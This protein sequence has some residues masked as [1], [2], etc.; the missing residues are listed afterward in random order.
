MAEVMLSNPQ[1]DELYAIRRILVGMY[2]SH[3][4]TLR[5]DPWRLHY[6]SSKVDA[7][8]AAIAAFI[9]RN[10]VPAAHQEQLPLLRQ[11]VAREVASALGQTG[12][13]IPGGES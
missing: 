11:D 7:M 5:P 8:D 9:E 12:V 2:R 6:Y 1:L 13:R 10:N 4:E 3:S